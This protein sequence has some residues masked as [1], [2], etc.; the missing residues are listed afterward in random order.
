[1]P[2]PEDSIGIESLKEIINN[3]GE[4]GLSTFAK[5]MAGFQKDLEKAVL[6]DKN[7]KGAYKGRD[8]IYTDK[9]G[10][11]FVSNHWPSEVCNECRPEM[12]SHPTNQG[13]LCD[14]H[15]IEFRELMSKPANY[16]TFNIRDVLPKK[17]LGVPPTIKPA[18]TKTFQDMV[19]EFMDV[20]DVPYPPIPDLPPRDEVGLCVRLLHEEGLEVEAE[21]LKTLGSSHSILNSSMLA[22]EL[23]DL[24]YV[25][26]YTAQK[27]GIDLGEVFDAVHASNMTKVDPSTGKATRDKGGK[28][29]KGTHYK[30]PPVYDII[31]KQAGIE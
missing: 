22:K 18:P 2:T 13:K 24:I 12:R 7:N 29:L 6:I 14:R 28:I 3:L 10:K 9:D 25:C 23:C 21:L 20:C 11:P 26:L 8:T 19:R 15:L 5:A 4:A 30:S 16:H 27:F 31:K 17:E 1:M